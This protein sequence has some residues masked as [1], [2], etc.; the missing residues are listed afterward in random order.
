MFRVL[1]V[2]LRMVAGKRYFGAG[3]GSENEE[4]QRCRRVFRELFY[5]LG[6]FSLADAVP[7]FRWLDWSGFE[8][9]LK[10]TGRE[11][12]S[13]AQEWLDEHRRRKGSGEDNN[14]TQDFVDVMMSV[15]DGKNL[16]DYDA[17]TINKATCLV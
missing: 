4:A 2:I 14:C 13:I 10:K 17:D 8:N 11:M 12:D 7:F 6:L 3:D 1:H 16:G 15:L 9:T 5:L